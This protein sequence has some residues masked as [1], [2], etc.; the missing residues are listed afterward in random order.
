MR[1]SLY[2]IAR[3][4]ARGGGALLAKKCDWRPKSA[5]QRLMARQKKDRL[6]N[7][8]RIWFFNAQCV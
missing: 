2:G 7:V 6:E 1:I 8:G 5:T 3:R 4:K